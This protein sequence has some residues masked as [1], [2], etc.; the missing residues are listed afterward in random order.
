ML[1]ST[2]DDRLRTGDRHGAAGDLGEDS[3]A[4]GVRDR[5][6]K[7]KIDSDELRGESQITTARVAGTES[8]ARA[9]A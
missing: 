2:K 5:A 9:D 8:R 4:I 3:V 6:D 1:C 7:Y